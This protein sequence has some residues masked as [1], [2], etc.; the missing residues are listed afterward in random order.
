MLSVVIRVRFRA[1]NGLKNCLFMEVDWLNIVLIVETVVKLV[2][3]FKSFTI[4]IFMMAAI[5]VLLMMV[6]GFMATLMLVMVVFMAMRV[7]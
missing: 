3:G 6:N 4:M 2:V 5:L 1:I 7:F